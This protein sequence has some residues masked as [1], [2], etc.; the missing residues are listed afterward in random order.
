MSS[1]RKYKCMFCNK[2]FERNKLAS[3]IDK[4]HDDMLCPEKD[5]LQIELYLILVI[6]K[7]L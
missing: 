1:A 7:N 2:T 5:L 3:H 6:E 4:Y